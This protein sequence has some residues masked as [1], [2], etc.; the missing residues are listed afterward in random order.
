MDIHFD[1]PPL[2]G[3][4]FRF[5]V[6]GGSGRTR[7]HVY[8]GSETLRTVDC[9]DPPCHEMVMIPSNARGLALL[10]L[11]RDAEGNTAEVRLLVAESNSSSSSGSASGSSSMRNAA[12]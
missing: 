12:G 8:L 6:V 4:G 5:Y 11:A 10:L 7:T 2:T 3:E 1:A 9:D